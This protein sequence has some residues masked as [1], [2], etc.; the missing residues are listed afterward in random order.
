MSSSTFIES[1]VTLL[2][3]L[4][5]AEGSYK[6][7]PISPLASNGTVGYSNSHANGFLGAT[8]NTPELGLSYDT[9]PF[10]PAMGAADTR[11]SVV[12][13]DPPPLGNQTFWSFDSISA[14]VYRY[15]R[16]QSVNLGS[17]YVGET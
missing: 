2:R 13:Y 5:L 12:S 10:H 1:F 11:C 6:P 3:T 4:S 7:F 8:F 14:T 17:W 15:R 9:I 16:Q